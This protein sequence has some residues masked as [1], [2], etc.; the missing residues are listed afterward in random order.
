MKYISTVIGNYMTHIHYAT[1]RNQQNESGCAQANSHI[2]TKLS[3]ENLTYEQ[4][5]MKITL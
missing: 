3:I 2:H 4:N 5:G 1:F